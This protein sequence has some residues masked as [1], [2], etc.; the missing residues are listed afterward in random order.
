[1][2]VTFTMPAGWEAD[3][4]FV[5]KSG[6]DP[7]FG[8]VFM[9]V[10]NIYAEGCKWVLVDPAPGPTRR[11]PGLGVCEVAGVRSRCADVTVDGFEGKQ[12]QYT[13]PDYN[14]EECKGGMFGI[15]WNDHNNSGGAGAPALG[16]QAPKQQNGLWIL[17]VDGTRLVILA[18]DSPNMSAPDQTDLDG[19]FSSIQI[20]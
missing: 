8:L 9:D 14:E 17:D 16:A 7:V 19:I 1:V 11:R 4:A 5:S 13:V 10:G 18:G 15:F 20:G 12:I 3:G 2:P 6:A